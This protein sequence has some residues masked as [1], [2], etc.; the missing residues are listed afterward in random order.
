[1]KRAENQ[2]ML[3]DLFPIAGHTQRESPTGRRRV[4]DGGQAGSTEAV[5]TLLFLFYSPALLGVCPIQARQM[6]TVFVVIALTYPTPARG[7]GLEGGPMSP[8][9]KEGNK[10]TERQK[11]GA[12]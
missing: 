5:P 7:A 2:E 6:E 12:Q 10:T 4:P 9:G 8:L 3:S 1:M 11:L